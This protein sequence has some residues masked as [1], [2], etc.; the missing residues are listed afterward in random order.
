MVENSAEGAD[1]DFEQAVQDGLDA[2]PAE[3][4]RSMSNVTIVVEDEPPGGA[5]L[6]GLIRACR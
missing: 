5:P 1:V 2:L 4:R 3:L 6:L